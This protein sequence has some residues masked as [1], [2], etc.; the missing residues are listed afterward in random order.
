MELDEIEL[1]EVVTEE[2]VVEE[3]EEEAEPVEETE[4]AEEAEEEELSVSFEGEEP[5]EEQ[6][7]PE[8]VKATRKESRELAK[9]NR[10]L[11][12]QL[13]ELQGAKKEAVLGERPKLEQF[14]YDESKYDEAL[15]AWLAK[16]G[17]VEAQEAEKRKDEEKQ[18]EAWQ[19]KLDDYAT[20]RNALSA[21]AKDFTEAEETVRAVLSPARQ[22]M[23]LDAV[24]GDPTIL[25]Y[26]LGKNP[27]KAQA[28]ADIKNDVQF[29]A[30]LVRLESGM[31][32]SGV[33]RKAAPE[34]RVGSKAG[35]PVSSKTSLAR[36]EAD[37]ERTG[38]YTTYFAAKKRLKE[39]G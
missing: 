18:A 39:Q 30:E 12:R 10:D 25:V 20:A 5:E 23:L 37:A 22:S 29:I 8:W 21:K 34:K 6:E 24:K 19:A 1:E 7:A 16:K 36:L 4:V 31:K 27:K 38:D 35:A 28:L 26:A 32:V 3:V 2:D 14:D 17:Q 33:K 13:E 11:Q 9:K 15:E